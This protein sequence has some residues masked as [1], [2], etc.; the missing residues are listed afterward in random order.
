M[1]SESHY[2]GLWASSP[3]GTALS[4]WK[5]IWPHYRLTNASAPSSMSHTGRG[6]SPIGQNGRDET[7]RFERLQHREA[8]RIRIK[9]CIAAHQVIEVGSAVLA[10]WLAQAVGKRQ[11][12]QIPEHQF[13]DQRLMPT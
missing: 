13:N 10:G 7:A 2:G 11:A 6:G 1:R 5:L 9:S 8:F 12:C 4:G 3:S